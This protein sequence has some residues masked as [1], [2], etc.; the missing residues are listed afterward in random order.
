[1]RAADS[2]ALSWLGSD[3]SFMRF[4]DRLSPAD[5]QRLLTVFVRVVV[6]SAVETERRQQR[7]QRLVRL[8]LAD[9][10]A[11]IAAEPTANAIW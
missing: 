9:A 10:R 5:A 2:L 7:R 4:H 3:I 6:G 11:R 1:M 8:D